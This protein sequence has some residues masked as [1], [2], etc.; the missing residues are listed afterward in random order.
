M[1]MTSAQFDRLR[2]LLIDTAVTASLIELEA[3]ADKNDQLAEWA[4]HVRVNCAALM[5][6]SSD[7]P[8]ATD[9][10]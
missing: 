9:G 10:E 6:L 2:N 5:G 7:L 1:M 4:E 8:E 3:L